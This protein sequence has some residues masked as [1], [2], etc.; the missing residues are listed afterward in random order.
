MKARTSLHTKLGQNT[1]EYLIMLTLVAV[2]SI[3]VM[4]VFGK[5]VKEKIGMVTA[6]IG[7]DDAAYTLAKTASKTDSAEGHARAAKD[8]SMQGVVQGDLRI[9]TA[10]AE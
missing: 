6:A 10:A 5:T 2:G 1:A 3:A 9:G 8:S 4:S 7:G